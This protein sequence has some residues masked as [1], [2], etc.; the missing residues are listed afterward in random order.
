MPLKRWHASSAWLWGRGG[1]PWIRGGRENGGN[2]IQRP[3]GSGSWLWYDHGGQLHGGQWEGAES[4][5]AADGSSRAG[6]GGGCRGQGVR[7]R[8][9]RR[10]QNFF[11]LGACTTL[12]QE[13]VYRTSNYAY[14][15]LIQP[16]DRWSSVSCLML[17]MGLRS[18]T[19]TFVYTIVWLC[20]WIITN[21]NNRNMITIFFRNHE[22][23]NT[24]ILYIVT[25]P[26]V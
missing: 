10:D 8:K 23:N 5:A 20:D 17:C 11:P 24:L 1:R 16:I 26:F 2:W 18:T 13:V 19:D 25:M 6:G 22:N 21:I 3:E 12:T 7:R 4:R 9:K 14:K 15:Q